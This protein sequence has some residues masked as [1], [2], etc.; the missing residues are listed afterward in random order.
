MV[1]HRCDVQWAIDLVNQAQNLHG[2]SATVTVFPITKMDLELPAVH[3]LYVP[4]ESASIQLCFLRPKPKE[5]KKRDRSFLLMPP[6]MLDPCMLHPLQF[7]GPPPLCI[8]SSK[9]GDA[10]ISKKH[11]PWRHYL[12]ECDIEVISTYLHACGHANH[13]LSIAVIALDTN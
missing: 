1:S 7:I 10:I 11:R 6:P 4:V 2:N 8:E 9:P 13:N 3:R 12:D 5:R